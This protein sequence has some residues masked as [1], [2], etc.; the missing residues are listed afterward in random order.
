MK[1]KIITSLFIGLALVFGTALLVS[2]SDKK[3]G[4]AAAPYYP[5]DVLPIYPQGYSKTWQGELRLQDKGMYRDFLRDHNGCSSLS[6]GSPDSCDS[7]DDHAQI[8]LDTDGLSLATATSTRGTIRIL[9]YTDRATGNWGMWGQP[10]IPFATLIF[11]GPVSPIN[12]SSGF[13]IRLLG[14]GRYGTSSE[15]IQL[16]ANSARLTDST[17]QVELKYRGTVIGR[18]SITNLYF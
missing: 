4:G 13:E 18:A 10:M 7:M 16:I 5:P 12:N 11:N 9:T 14:N 15:F 3:S 2:C 1:Q 6:F 8:V 17:I